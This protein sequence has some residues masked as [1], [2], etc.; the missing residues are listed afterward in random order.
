MIR[1]K[2]YESAVETLEDKKQN[3]TLT[4]IIS[5]IKEEYFSD[6]Q[7]NEIPDEHVSDVNESEIDM[8]SIPDVENTPELENKIAV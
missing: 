6:L 5:G 4:D 2:Q 1:D 7:P 3:E 8:S